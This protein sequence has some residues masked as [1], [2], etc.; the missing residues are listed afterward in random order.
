MLVQIVSYSKKKLSKVTNLLL[1]NQY[2]IKLIRTK[3]NKFLEA[4]K[5]YNL[6]S[7]QNLTTNSKTKKN[8]ENK[9]LF[10]NL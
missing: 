4:H 5:I 2:A 8:S 6:T 10:F 1:K 3:I 7:K 9:N